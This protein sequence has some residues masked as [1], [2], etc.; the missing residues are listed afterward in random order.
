[1][2]LGFQSVL[3]IVNQMAELSVWARDCWR[4]RTGV[5]S[6]VG[7]S[8]LAPLGRP[9]QLSRSRAHR[10]GPCMLYSQPGVGVF[11]YRLSVGTSEKIQLSSLIAAF[12]V[13]RDL[14][15]SEA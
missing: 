7:I 8:A 15:V 12:Q 6:R 9:Q 10:W 2:V 3:G 14:I 1:M 4:T 11:R 13:T 5:L